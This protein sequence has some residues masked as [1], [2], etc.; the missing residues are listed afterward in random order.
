[1]AEQERILVVDDESDIIEIV[2]YTLENSGYTV[3]VAGNG[4]EAISKTHEFNPDLI[5]LDIMLPR[6]NGFDVCRVIKSSIFTGH[7]PIIMFSAKKEVD[8]K[9]LATEVG[10]DDYI[11]KPFNRNELISRI[12]M[13]I[14]RTRIQSERNPLSGLPGNVAIESNIRRSLVKKSPVAFAVVDI[15]NFKPFN[16]KYGFDKGDE[17]IKAVAYSL[18][19]A[20]SEKGSREDFVGHI[21]GDDFTAILK[22]ETSKA[23]LEKT[24]ELFEERTKSLFAPE[25]TERGYYTSKDRAGEVKQYPASLSLSIGVVDY[26]G[27]FDLDYRAL[28]DTLTELKSSGKKEAGSVIKKDRRLHSDEVI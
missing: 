26:D 4:E 1:M 28:I 7:I 13:V 12:K 16:D 15:D 14:S 19:K 9:V 11:Q 3:E 5:L 27:S 8:D 24:I 2:T 23:V 22:L 6:M 18:L 17:V 20:I 10:A 21:G 25:D